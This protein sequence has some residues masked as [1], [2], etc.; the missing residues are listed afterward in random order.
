MNTSAGTMTS[1]R[2]K[3]PGQGG[4]EPPLYAAC[5]IRADMQFIVLPTAWNIGTLCMKSFPS[6]LSCLQDYLKKYTE[7][8][9]STSVTQE[10][11]EPKKK[12]RKKAAAAGMAPAI[13]I[14]DADATGFASGDRRKPPSFAAG[15][16]D[17]G[18][19]DG[20]DD[21]GDNEEGQCLGGGARE[22]CM[23]S[24]I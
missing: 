23:D 3:N 12:K 24:L 10:Y 22:Q 6:G 16:A 15:A 13:R 8:G 1:R 17:D 7:G 5:Y 18:D 21:G 20:D 2:T 19:D 11:Q 14:V 4:I 9:S